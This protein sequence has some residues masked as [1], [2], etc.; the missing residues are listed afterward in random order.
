MK[1][2]FFKN[3][4][5]Q[6]G[7]ECTYEVFL[8]ACHEQSLL[9]LCKK[10]ALEA[11]ADKRSELKRGLPVVTWQSYFEGRRKASE[12]QPSGLFMLDIDHVDNPYELYR[13]KIAGRLSKLSRLEDCGQMSANFE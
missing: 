7:E 8:N 10:I 5:A 11:D 13:A 4:K 3:A 12:A 9:E 6:V 2:S 1:F